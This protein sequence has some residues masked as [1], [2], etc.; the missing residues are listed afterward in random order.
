[1]LVFPALD[2]PFRTIAIEGLIYMAYAV[3]KVPDPADE[4]NM[5]VREPFPKGR[6]CRA[7]D[8]E[9]P[10]F[11]PKSVMFSKWIFYRVNV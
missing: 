9:R 2:V 8:S 10:N 7:G 3:E 5:R 4:V 6:S 1:M 11:P